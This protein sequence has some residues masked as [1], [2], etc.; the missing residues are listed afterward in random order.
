ME[1]TLWGKKELRTSLH[2]FKYTAFSQRTLEA[3]NDRVLTNTRISS[4]VIQGTKN[5]IK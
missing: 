2:C 4:K 3:K 5:G 1:S